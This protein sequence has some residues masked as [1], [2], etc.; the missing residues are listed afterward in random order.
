MQSGTRSCPVCRGDI[1]PEKV[2]KVTAF[3]PTMAELNAMRTVLNG[4]ELVDLTLEDDNAPT[5]VDEND[6]APTPVDEKGKGKAIVKDEE[7]LGLDLASLD[8]GD[9]FDPSAKMLKM[10]EFIKQCVPLQLTSSLTELIILGFQGRLLPRMTKS[11][12]THNVR[13]RCMIRD[14]SLMC[15]CDRDV[16]D[17]L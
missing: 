9:N 17:H 3:E 16:D 5:P 7:D 13:V 1:H 12:A 11:F 14:M 8:R 4:S 10:T 6:S 15:P 2:F